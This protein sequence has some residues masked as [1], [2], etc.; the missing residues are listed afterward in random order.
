M[1]ITID[2][3]KIVDG[4]LADGEWTKEDFEGNDAPYGWSNEI[5]DSIPEYEDAVYKEIVERLNNADS[6]S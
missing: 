3:S 5:L 1:L 4:L 2:T 6:N